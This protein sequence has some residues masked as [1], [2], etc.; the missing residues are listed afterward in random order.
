MKLKISLI[1]LFLTFNTTFSQEKYTISGYIQDAKTAE[2]LIL[3]TIFETNKSKGATSNTYGFYSLTL[4]K[5]EVN[6]Y[7]SFVG[8]QAKNLVFE[9]KKDTIINFN[10]KPSLSLDEVILVARK[11]P[12]IE[13]RTQMSRISVPISAIEKIPTILGENDVLKTLQLLPGVQGGTE[14]MNG[15]YV[16][17]GSPDQNLVI[18]D[19]VPVYNVSHLLGFLSVFN[20]DAIKG[21]S[22]TKGGFPARYGGRLSSVIEINMKEG[23]KKEF[24]GEG[25]IGLL[26][27]RLTLEG[28]IV[29][30][31]SSFMI[32]GRRNYFDIIAKPIIKKASKDSGDDLDLSTYFYDLNAK[33]NHKFNEK[34]SIYL[35]AYLG[36]DVFKN[37]FKENDFDSDDFYRT[38][39]GIDWGNVIT[40]MRWNYKINNKLFANTT[41]TYSK[42]NFDFEVGE[43][44][45]YEG[46]HNKFEAK[47]KSGIYDIAGK[48]DFDYIPNPNHH[49]RFGFGNTYH[50]YNPG[51][52]ALKG[53]FDEE[54][55]ETLN[56]QK[57]EY[58]NEYFG[59]LEDELQFGKLKANIGLH[60][61]GFTIGNK[62]YNSLQ[63]RIGLRYLVNKKWSLKASYASMAQYINLL[64][65]ESIG[66]PTDLW[67]PS[68]ERI[69][70]Q[71]SWQAAFGVATTFKNELEFSIEGYYKKMDNVI[72][73]KEGA[74]F[75][76]VEE[77][78]EDKITQGTGTAYGLEVLLQKKRGKT[79]GWI[80]YTLA[81]NN[82]QFD[83]INS[84]KEYP[85]KFDRRHDFEMVAIH[86][87]SDRLHLSGTWVYSTGNAISLTEAT[88]TSFDQNGNLDPIS[89]VGTKNSYRMPSY[90]RLDVGLEFLKK[91]K[92]GERAWII[93]VYNAYMRSNPFYVYLGE[94]FDTNKKQYKQVSL[95]PLVPSVSYRFKF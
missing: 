21:V 9:L 37:D 18:L 13:Q 22:L 6:L 3:A 38:K 12:K 23:N 24:H 84:G 87:F 50:T 86:K 71:T 77:N 48:V 30:D 70:P 28:P 16:R 64:T 32:S 79:T 93:G 91:K 67:V 83:E 49:I 40:A 44:V 33:V 54:D 85:F 61:S 36:S 88:Y 75:F 41:L 81:W 25:A 43:E 74:S 10:L 35:S 2:R 68:T 63:P 29:K 7:A 26:S 94:N 60:A 57:K 14:G 76:N 92:W 78:W 45:F 27:S 31:K 69:K 72:S 1:L 51:A 42:F 19:G 5:G 39:A 17:G 55:F 15:V 65:N 90:H 82:R 20:T 95:I 34:H 58:S 66:L 46:E 56:N 53:D 89:I 4:A 52:L 62:T 73:Y 80:G 11:T 8:Y 47:Y 59:Y